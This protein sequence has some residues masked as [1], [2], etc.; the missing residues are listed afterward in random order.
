MT[1]EKS[2]MPLIITISLFIGVT[3]SA[4]DS[5]TYFYQSNTYDR[6]NKEYNIPYAYFIYRQDT[7]VA[8]FWNHTQEK[9]TWWAND[10]RYLGWG[11]VS[12]IIYD[13][14]KSAWH[15]FLKQFHKNT[16][17]RTN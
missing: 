15:Y 5:I 16:L 17:K 11:I 4:Q 7:I 14:E 6:I 13:K 9:E 1:I 8:T 3:V 12:D 2:L 10:V